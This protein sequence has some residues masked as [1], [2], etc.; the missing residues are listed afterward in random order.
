MGYTVAVVGAS[1]NVGREILSILDER[2]FPVDKVHAV[3]SSRSA[4][5]EVSTIYT[6]KTDD[7]SLISDLPDGTYTV[8]VTNTTNGNC[9]TT[10]QIAITNDPSTPF[11]EF[12]ETNRKPVHPR[13][14]RDTPEQT[15]A[16]N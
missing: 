12:Y 8:V 15:E 16:T 7:T 5:Q 14:R 13:G 1:G 6:G 3:A 10:Q 4:G 11:I 9:E 2:Q